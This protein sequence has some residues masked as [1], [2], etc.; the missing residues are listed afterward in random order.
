MYI[1]IAERSQE[2]NDRNVRMQ[3]CTKV[4]CVIAREKNC[5]TMKGSSIFHRS[6]LAKNSQQAST[7]DHWLDRRL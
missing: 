1:V 5:P 4:T 7:S 6:S 2:K 3:W